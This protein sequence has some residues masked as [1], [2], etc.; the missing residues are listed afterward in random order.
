MYNIF[1]MYMTET[2]RV[3]HFSAFIRELVDTL[4]SD[5]TDTPMASSLHRVSTNS[6]MQYFHKVHVVTLGAH[7]QEGYGTCPVYL[8]SAVCLFTTN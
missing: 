5:E 4:C 3:L 2:P 7:A 1:T 6:Y 8:L